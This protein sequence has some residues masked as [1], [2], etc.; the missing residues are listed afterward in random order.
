MVRRRLRGGARRNAARSSRSRASCI[1]TGCR[2]AVDAATGKARPAYDAL[3]AALD[4]RNDAGRPSLRL[5]ALTRLAEIA[6]RLEKPA[7][8]ERHFR[9]ALALGVEDDFLL[10]AYADFLL[11]QGRPQEVDALLKKWARSDNAAAAPR[12]RGEG[13]E[14]AGG[15]EAHA[16]ARRALRRRRAARR[17]AAPRRGSAL[18]ARAQRRRRRLRSPPRWRT[19]RSQ[20]EPRDAKVLLEAALAAAIARPRR[21]CCA[22]WRKAASRT[23]ACGASRRSCK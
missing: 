15:A 3:K 19:G 11:E 14:A 12:A 22:G 6:G 20:R 17:A 4:G 2:A 9:D 8:A 10:A 23:P 5:W 21:R 13:A 16:G 7:H 1:A 18:P